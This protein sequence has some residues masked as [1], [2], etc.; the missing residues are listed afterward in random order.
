MTLSRDQRAFLS[1]TVGSL[2]IVFAS[3]GC[4]T[5]SSSVRTSP[6]QEDIKHDTPSVRHAYRIFNGYCWNA[7]GPPTPDFTA[8]ERDGLLHLTVTGGHSKTQ[9]V[10][11][12]DCMK[13]HGVADGKAIRP[14]A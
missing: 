3:A 11:V 14:G 12:I 2:L 7:A 13:E 1:A 8:F 5:T 9:L 10:R 4:S 6:S